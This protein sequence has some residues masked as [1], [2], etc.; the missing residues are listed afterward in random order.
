MRI[1]MGEDYTLGELRRVAPLGRESQARVLRGHVLD[2]LKW[3]AQRLY[4][5][6]PVK[7]VPSWNAAIDK[8]I[9]EFAKE[10]EI[11]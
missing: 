2:E 11:K 7:D 3:L 8:M 6:H 9:E 1:T 4:S 10:R 5:A